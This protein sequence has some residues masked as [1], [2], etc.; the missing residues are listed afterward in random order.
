[1]YN[2]TTKHNKHQWQF[3]TSQR[4]TTNINDSVQHH[5]ETQQTSMTVY[6][7]TTSVVFRCDVV[8]CHWCLL[9]FV[10]MLYT[11]IDVCCV[12]LWCCKHHNE[13]QQTSMTVYNITTKHNRHQWQFTTSQRSTTDINDSVQHHNETQQTSMT[14]CFVVMLYTVIDVCCVSLWCCTLSVMSVV[15]RNRHQWQCTTSQR[16]T[17]D[18]NDSVQHHN[19]TQ[20]TSMTVYNITTKHNKHQ[21]QCGIVMSISLDFGYHVKVFWFST[22]REHTWWTIFQKRVVPVY[23]TNN[24]YDVDSDCGEMWSVIGDLTN[25]L[26]WATSK[27]HLVSKYWSLFCHMC[28]VFSCLI[29]ANCYKIDME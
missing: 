28:H 25:P 7:I 27:I 13:A 15:F 2:I 26:I 6:N 17:T 12:S 29:L 19:E 8:H 4:N 1:V 3:T 23:L 5:N 10:V 9:C 11:V 14:L 18:I 20:Q 21:W 16:N 24:A 22:D